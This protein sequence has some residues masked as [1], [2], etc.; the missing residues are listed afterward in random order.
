VICL[1]EG[2][3]AAALGAEQDV[4][5][6][7]AP[8]MDYVTVVEAHLLAGRRLTWNVNHQNQVTAAHFDAT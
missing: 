8:V 6:G 3:P 5:G 4:L 1:A 7:T 2:N